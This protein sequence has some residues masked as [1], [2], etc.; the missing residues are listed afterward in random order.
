MVRERNSRPSL[1]S[2]DG[3]WEFYYAAAAPAL[4]RIRRRLEG[5]DGKAIFPWEGKRT[6]FPCGR[7]DYQQLVLCQENVL[8]TF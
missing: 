5:G 6:D 8:R 7:V 1:S 2:D 4:E 3:N